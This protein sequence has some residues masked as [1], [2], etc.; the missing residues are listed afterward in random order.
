M[1]A[2]PAQ[3]ASPALRGAALPAVAQGSP[4]ETGSAAG[5]IGAALCAGAAVFALASRG[6]KAPAIST[7]VVRRSAAPTMVIDPSHAVDAASTLVAAGSLS[8]PIPAFS[9]AKAFVMASS[10]LAI[11]SGMTI[12]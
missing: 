10:N 1:V 5:Q 11:I 12:Q 7:D 4:S 8:I 6:R 3:M 9:P 2:E